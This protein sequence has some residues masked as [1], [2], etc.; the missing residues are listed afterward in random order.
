MQGFNMGRYRPPSTLDTSLS[1]S[2]SKPSHRKQQLKAQPTVRFEMPFAIWCTTCQPEVIIGQGVRFNATKHVAGKYHS[3]TIWLF[4]MRHP[5]CGGTIEIQTDPKNTAYVVMSGARKRDYGD[6]GEVVPGQES[7]ITDEE[8]QKMRSAAFGK[9]EKTIHDRELHDASTERIEGL[10]QAAQGWRDDYSANQRLRK[11]FR[12]GRHERE[13][14]AAAN[15][16]LQ[17]RLGFGYELLPGTEEDSRRAA[18]VDFQ[19]LEENGDALSKPLFG[20]RPV[21]REGKRMLKSDK[22][23]EKQKGKFMSTL[24]GNTRVAKDPFLNGE[25]EKGPARIPGVKRKRVDDD[26]EEPAV[27]AVKG[28]A[29]GLVAYGSDSD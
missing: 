8:R 22:E 6:E 19:P 20:E 18:I 4:R 15:E 10:Q 1:A 28:A 13:K 24:M 26:P 16:V 14:E 25:R 27:K 2:S 29:A 23:K 5:A 7:I 17:D 21:A 9:L 12:N 3:T 11:A